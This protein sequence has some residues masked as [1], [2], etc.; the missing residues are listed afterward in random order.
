MSLNNA[1]V[2]VAQGVGFGSVAALAKAAGIT[3]VRAT[4]RS[5]SAAYDASP[6]EMSG[7][8]TVFGNGGTRLS[9]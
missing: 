5:P 6:L 4:P 7:A 9:P 3:S 1:T 8:Y 2:R